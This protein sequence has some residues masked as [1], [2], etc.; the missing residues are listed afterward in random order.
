MM[1]PALNISKRRAGE[2]ASSVSIV[3][4]GPSEPEQLR[5]SEGTG[6]MQGAFGWKSL[7]IEALN[8]PWICRWGRFRR[9]YSAARLWDRP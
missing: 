7:L 3:K 5:T 1:P 4:G 6:A 8:R 2:M 9:I